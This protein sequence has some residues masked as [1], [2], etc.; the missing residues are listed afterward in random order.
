MAQLELG[1]SQAA[2]AV[3]GA[4]ERAEHEF[5]HRLLAEAVGDDFEPPALLDE[6]P[7]EQVRRPDDS[8]MGDGQP[9]V[10]DAGFEVVLETSKRARQEIGVVGADRGLR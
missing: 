5:E 1:E 6:Q 10:G 8:A 2:P 3:R 9:Q 7:F 4:D